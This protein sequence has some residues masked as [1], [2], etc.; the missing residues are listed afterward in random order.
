MILSMDDNMTHSHKPDPDRR[1]SSD[2]VADIIRLSLQDESRPSGDALLDYDELVAIAKDVGVSSEQIDRAVFMLQEE[3]QTREKERGLWLRLKAHALV[4][5]GVNLLLVAINLISGSDIF[6]A[7]YSIFGWGLF[8]LGHY[9]GLRYAPQFVEMATQRTRNMMDMGYQSG[10]AG[11]EQV[12]FTTRDPM[13][14]TETSGIIRLEDGKL[15]V[16]YQTIDAIMGLVKSAVKTQEI[17][18][19]KLISVRI[20]QKLWSADLVLQGKTMA[21]LSDLPGVSRGQ[22]R[23]KLNRQS[24]NA[25]KALIWSSTQQSASQS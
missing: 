7:L 16:E 3:Q 10:G 22:L 15:I 24:V 12:L 13:G 2:E 6:W 17:P 1:Y 23:V 20:D 8:L 11:E 14:M 9:A 5:A 4:F 19:D 18:L 25:A 21:A